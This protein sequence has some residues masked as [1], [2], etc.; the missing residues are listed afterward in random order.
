MQY[1]IQS[2]VFPT[3]SKHRGCRK[4]F[5]RGSRGILDTNNKSLSLG[6]GQSCD[7][8]TYI[9]ACSYGK[10]K[11]Y[12]GISN[13][14]LHLD[15]EGNAE[16]TFLGYT[17]KALAIYRKEYSVKKISEKTRQTINYTFPENNEMMVGF[18]ISAL[19]KCTIHGGYY[20]AE[21]AKS[22]IN[23]V[24]LSLAT[25]T[26]G[27]EDFIKKNVDIIKK[28]ILDSN[29]EI[30]KNLYL[31]VVDNGRTLTEKDIFGKHV[32]LHPNINAGG[33][34]GFARGMMESLAQKPEATHVLLMDDDVLVLPES[35]K[36]T[37]SLLK[38]LKDEYKDYF[39]SGAMLYYE[40]PTKQL[41]DIGTIAKIPNSTSI[42][43]PLKNILDHERLEDNLENEIILTK[44]KN[45]Y[46]AWW[47]CCIPTKVIKENGLP[48]PIFIRCDD[49]EYSLRCNANILTMN[50]ICI[51]H[52]G[53]AT[54]Y[55]SAFDLYQQYRNWLIAQS[56]SNI[57]TKIDLYS[58][59]RDSFRLEMMRFNYGAAELIVKALED[60]MRGPN[61]IKKANGE[62]IAKD[63]FLL[64][65]TF[66]PLEKFSNDASFTIKDI[67]EDSPA[68]IKDRAI[69]KFTW[70]GQRFCPRCFERKGVV[71]ISF[72]GLFQLHKIILRNKLLAINPYTLTGTYR[73]KDKE[74]FKKLMKRYKKAKRKY[75]K[76]KTTIAKQYSDSKKELTSE[77]FWK[78]YL[79]INQGN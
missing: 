19:S 23:N 2:L 66:E 21:V 57:F 30:A 67:Y 50:G 4:L 36:R 7:F 13:L 54:K 55:N 45:S 73:I 74:K 39:I 14:T 22:A 11:K 16:I 63:N 64:N 35:I 47:Y 25:T 10:W 68:T 69:A 59:I 42:Y 20:T 15:I 62:Q 1:K 43:R 32:Y 76:H 77:K 51:W 56:T 26:C 27:K 29:D 18:E 8:V 28:E 17:K 6:Y 58:I 5:Y 38:L 12:T 78:N 3:E 37:Y 60:Y 75:K 71:P 34:G 70:N 40:D 33:S 72:D 79:N 41:E 48:L 46:A 24:T 61:F 53:F 49:S 52:M 65:D 44:Y 9:N 31:H